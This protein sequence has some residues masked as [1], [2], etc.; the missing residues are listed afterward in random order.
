MSTEQP[1]H[2]VGMA[3]SVLPLLN[4]FWQQSARAAADAQ[5]EE[6]LKQRALTLFNATRCHQAVSVAAMNV[7]S[8][9]SLCLSCL[10]GA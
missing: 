5:S 2:H 3:A 7:R 6:P 8:L 10:D 4:I 9:P 1:L